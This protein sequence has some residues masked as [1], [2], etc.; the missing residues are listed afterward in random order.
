MI[1]PQSAAFHLRRA[2]LDRV[3][4]R[5]EIDRDDRVPALARELA[6]RRC[7]LDA[8]VVHENID[9][10]KSCVACAIICSICV[11]LRHVG[12]AVATPAPRTCR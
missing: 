2:R 4:S 9:A 10:P 11:R 6:N 12:A 5:R 7:V 8:G 3:E 1:R